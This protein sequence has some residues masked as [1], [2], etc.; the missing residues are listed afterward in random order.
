M[1]EFSIPVPVACALIAVLVLTQTGLQS[2]VGLFMEVYYNGDTLFYVEQSS[3]STH[4]CTH[5]LIHILKEILDIQ[6]H[7]S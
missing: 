4:I 5:Y 3:V 6:M 2:L 7:L 1:D